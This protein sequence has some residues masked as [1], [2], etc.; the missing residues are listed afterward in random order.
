MCVGYIF[1]WIICL[2]I[3]IL[4]SCI[5]HEYMVTHISWAVFY[6]NINISNILIKGRTQCRRL[7][8]L[9]GVWGR[10]VFKPQALPTQM[11]RGWGSNTQAE[12]QRKIVSSVPYMKFILLNQ[13]SK[14]IQ[15]DMTL[16][17]QYICWAVPV[18]LLK[19]LY[20]LNILLNL[21]R[22]IESKFNSTPC[23]QYIC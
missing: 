9:C 19:T 6:I 15:V 10:I 11:C 20:R 22:A 8:A 14:R 12:N 23:K 21:F 13:S 2:W 17:K 16:C 4:I 3:S 1:N 18:L 7:P 5:I